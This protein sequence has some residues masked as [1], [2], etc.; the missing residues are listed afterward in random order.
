MLYAIL[1]GIVVFLIGN[2]F[3]SAGTAALIGFV[4]GLLVFFGANR[5]NRL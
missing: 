5:P 3:L 4:V 2:L 1:V